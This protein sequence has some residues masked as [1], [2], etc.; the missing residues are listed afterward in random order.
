MEVEKIIKLLEKSKW[1][2]C[3]QCKR[4]PNCDCLI[5]SAQDYNNDID[6]IIGAI[7]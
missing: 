7:K 6:K 2:N 5:M 3:P 1:Q 4:D